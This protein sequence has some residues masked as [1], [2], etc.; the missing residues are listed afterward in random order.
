MSR[1]GDD[2]AGEAVE[3]LRQHEVHQVAPTHLQLPGRA[4]QVP[5]HLQELLDVPDR[6]LRLQR[7]VPRRPRAHLPAVEVLRRGGVHQVHP[8]HLPLRRRGGQV[9]RHLQ[10]LRG[11]H[12]QAVPLRL[13]RLLPRRPPAQV[14]LG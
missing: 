1:S 14:H 8:A 12:H 9:R 3:V 7:P 5:R 4:G 11:V 2:G 13:Q 6:P 10:E